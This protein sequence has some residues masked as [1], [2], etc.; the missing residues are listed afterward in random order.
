MNSSGSSFRGNDISIYTCAR[1]PVYVNEWVKY[2]AQRKQMHHSMRGP[3]YMT[4]ITT[5]TIDEGDR[6]NDF[7]KI[8]RIVFMPNK[9]TGGI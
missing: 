2:S 6:N 9:E 8:R 3:K 5:L 4:Y 7:L 1:S